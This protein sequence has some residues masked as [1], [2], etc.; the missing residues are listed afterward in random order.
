MIHTTPTKVPLTNTVC[1]LVVP[2]SGSLA[3]GV[4]LLEQFLHDAPTPRKMA[5]VELQWV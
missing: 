3:Q 1:P 2:L 4:R 5:E